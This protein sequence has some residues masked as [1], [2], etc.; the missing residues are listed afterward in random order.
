MLIK[1]HPLEC[2]VIPDYGKTIVVQFES[3]EAVDIA[4]R[5]P[6]RTLIELSLKSTSKILTVDDVEVYYNF[7]SNFLKGTKT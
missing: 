6:L 3:E 4:K 1:W 7:T 5:I 2:R